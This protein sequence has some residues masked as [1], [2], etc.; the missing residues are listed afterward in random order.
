MGNVD[1][2]EFSGAAAADCGCV[3]SDFASDFIAKSNGLFAGYIADAASSEKTKWA[4]S[5]NTATFTIGTLT[6][7]DVGT[8]TV[9]GSTDA[10]AIVYVKSNDG[11]ST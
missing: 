1:L 5:G 6:S 10:D 9:Q 4:I 7:T 2:I 3:A 11:S 8:L